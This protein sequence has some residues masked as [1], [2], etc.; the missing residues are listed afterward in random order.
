MTT[1]PLRRSLALVA[2]L[3]LT[4]SA[5]GGDDAADTTAPA[6]GGARKIT[7]FLIPSPNATAITALAADF[8][9]ETGIEV[10]ISETPYG[11]AHQK[12]ILAFQ[13]GNG[14]YDVVQFDNT[15]L[16]N[17]GSNGFLEPLQDRIAASA[18]YDINDFSP[19]IRD[20]GDY[21]GDTLGLILSTEP[22]LLWYRTDIYEELGLSVPE[23]WDE[24]LANARAIQDSGQAGGQLMGYA[25][26]VNAW[27]WYQLVWSFGG[28]LYD[29]QLNPTVNTPEAV[30][31]TEFYVETLAASSEG[32]IALTGDDVTNQ[33]ISADTGQMIQYSGYHPLVVD[34]ET[35]S[36]PDKIATA[37]VPKGAAD[38]IHL[39]GWNIGIPADSKNKDTAW[40]F[41]EYVMGKP[42]AKKFLEAGAAAPGRISTTTDAGL[43][44]ETPYLQLLNIPAEVRVERYPQLTVYP[45]FEKTVGDVLA[46]I[47]SGQVSIEDGL[48][49]MQEKLADVL[50][51]EPR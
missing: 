35:S 34:P 16:A 19:A 8:T 46:N 7:V 39:A 45:E 26:P 15:F 37:R 38:V 47:L 12:Q 50:A 42:N 20:Y 13:S 9:A 25:T 23:T 3:A 11:E 44:A 49:E 24:Y 2:V 17:Y 10:E 41:L 29:D 1:R 40:Q 22:F 27:W 32:A 48:A 4:L 30:A 21:K 31:A 43:L 14:Q 28:D 36:F 33:F 6:D 51:A 18:T 5:C